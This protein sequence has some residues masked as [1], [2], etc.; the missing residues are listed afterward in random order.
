MI[1]KRFPVAAEGFKYIAFL[2]LAAL[3]TA[4]LGFILLSAILLLL[5]LFT[6]YFFRDPDRKSINDPDAVVSPADGRV[7]EISNAPEEHFINMEMLR[8][9]IFLS[10]SDCHINRMP[11]S[12]KIKGTKHISGKFN[13]AFS[14]NSPKENERKATL[15]ETDRNIKIVLVQIAGILARRIVSYATVGKEFERSE[16][17]GMIKFGSRVDIYLPKW[18]K[19]LV[20]KG[21]K[22]RGGETIIACIRP[23]EDE[24]EKN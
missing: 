5:G 9:G 11:F 20:S 4:I 2:G 22:V 1:K 19:I 24:K 14:D 16:R 6:V 3:T 21:D 18:C 23:G 17:F 15:I 13:F 10:I 8:I 12:G 7:V